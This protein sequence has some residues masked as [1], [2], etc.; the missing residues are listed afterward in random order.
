MTVWQI[1]L[2]IVG[3]L[4]TVGFVLIVLDPKPFRCESCGHEYGD[5]EDKS[6]CPNCGK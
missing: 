6:L 3:L 4:A 2:T 1:A 5:D